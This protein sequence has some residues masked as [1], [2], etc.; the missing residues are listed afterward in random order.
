MA[1]VAEGRLYIEP[2]GNDGGDIESAVDEP[3]QP[4]P[5]SH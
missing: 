3:Y 5:T 1:L 2:A 4:L